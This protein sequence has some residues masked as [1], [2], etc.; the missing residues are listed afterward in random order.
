MLLSAL[1]FEICS[2]PFADPKPRN[3][4]AGSSMVALMDH[5]VCDVKHCLR[6]MGK[7]LGFLREAWSTDRLERFKSRQIVYSAPSE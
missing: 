3:K 2:V 6:L 7:L 5:V 1:A 4:P